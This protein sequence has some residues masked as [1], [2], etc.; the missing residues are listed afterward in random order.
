MKWAD[1][2]GDP[3]GNRSQRRLSSLRLAADAHTMPLGFIWPGSVRELEHST[4]RSSLKALAAQAV[5]PH[6]PTLTKH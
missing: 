1:L 6:M 2:V 4:W 5:T 3:G